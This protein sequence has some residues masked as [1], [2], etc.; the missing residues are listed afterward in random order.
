MKVPR[1]FITETSISPAGATLLLKIHLGPMRFVAAKL[2]IPNLLIRR[3]DRATNEAFKS[4][5]HR[6]REAETIRILTQDLKRSA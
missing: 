6:T 1:A 4:W 3:L 2:F 5:D